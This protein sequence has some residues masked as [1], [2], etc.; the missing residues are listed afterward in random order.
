MDKKQKSDEEI[1]SIAGKSG[2]E[3]S[4]PVEMM[5]RL[6]DSIKELNKNTKKYSCILIG[7]TI[8][9]TITVLVQIYLLV[10]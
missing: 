6:K 10:K 7:L 2:E 8:I 5:K 1:I 4:A 9:M 3:N